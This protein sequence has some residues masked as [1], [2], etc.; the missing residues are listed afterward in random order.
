MGG[1]DVIDAGPG[2]DIVRADGLLLPGYL[3]SLPAADHGDDF[4]DAGPGDDLVIGGAASDILYGGP[5]QDRLVGDMDGPWDAPLFVPLDLH[6]ADWIDGEDGDDT[7]EGG[8]QGDQLWGGLGNDLLWGDL[9]AVHLAGLSVP[10]QALGDDTLDGGDGRDSLIGGGGDD[11]LAGGA[12][13]DALWGD[14]G[15]V[16]L[17]G[18]WHG[19]DLL[20]GGDGDDLLHGG[21]RNDTL[22][23]GAGRDILHGDDALAVL[24]GA[25]HGADLLDG[26]AQ[27]DQL[28]G[29]GGADTLFGGDGDD[30][31]VGDQAGADAA[32]TDFDGADQLH[33]DAG[34]DRLSGGGGA[35]SLWGGA[36]DDQLEGGRGADWMAGGDGHDVYRVDDPGDR[37][38]EA[39][40]GGID[41]VIST[42][43][44]VLPDHVEHLLLAG[45]VA[46]QGTG[47]A[48]DNQMTGT[49]QAD[50]LVGLAGADTLVGGRGADTLAGG[51]GDDVF[52]IDDSGDVVLELA[53]EGTD[54]LRTSVS[55]QLPE[56]VERGLAL[57]DAAIHLHGNGLDNALF[58]SAASNLLR[59]AGGNDLLQG[60]GGDDTYVF[61]PG[62]GQDSI[63][64]RDLLRDAARPDVPA[65]RDVL[66]LTGGIRAADVLPQRIGDD[67]LLQFRDSQDRVM[68]AGHFSPTETQGTQQFDRRID[69]VEFDQD[70]AWSAVDLDAL[71]ARAASNRAPQVLQ[72]LPLQ[73]ARVGEP[74]Q[75]TLPTGTLVDPDAWDSLRYSLEAPAGATLPAWIHFD[76]ARQKLSGTP[77]DG[78]TGDRTVVIRATDLYGLSVGL[79]VALRIT[80]PLIRGTAG[81]DTLTG[82]PMNDTLRGLAG[83]DLLTGGGGGD[84]F[85]GGSG[86]D[87]LQGSAWADTYLFGPGDGRDT[88]L[89]V[90]PSAGAADRLLLGPGI[91]PAELRVARQADDLVLSHVNGADQITVRG[92]FLLAGP[93]LAEV[94]FAD[95]TRWSSETLTARGLLQVGTEGNDLLVGT[96][97]DDSL[98]GQGG[99]DTLRGGSG[100]DLLDGG[101][102]H[103]VLDAGASDSR[104][105]GNRLLGGA[106]NDRLSASLSSRDNLLVGGP[107]DDALQGSGGADT[108][109]FDLG[110]GQD[111]ISETQSGAGGANDVL[112]FGS[113]IAPADIR[114]SRNLNDLILTHA[115]GT[116]AVT[117]GNWLARNATGS[118]T[119]TRI[120]TVQF[121]DGTVW[122]ST[123]LTAAALVTTGTA[124][125]DLLTGSDMDDQLFGLAGDDRLQGGQGRNLL[126]GGAGDDLLIADDGRFTVF[127]FP[128]SLVDYW[129]SNTLVGGAGNDT[130]WATTL[131]RDTVHEG[132]PGNDTLLG[133]AYNDTYRFA[134]GD[135]QDTI[136]EVAPAAG[137][138]DMLVWGAGITPAD[139]RPLRI[140]NDLVLSHALGQDQI[141]V[142]GWF[143]GTSQQIERL[144]FADGTLWDPAAVASRLATPVQG[145]AGPDSLSGGAGTDLLLGGDGADQLAGLGDADWLRGGAGNDTL[146]GGAGADVLLG[147]DPAAPQPVQAIGSLVVVA[148]GTVCEGLWPTME[149]WVGGSRLQTFQVSSSTW[150]PY[151]VTVPAGLQASAV[152]IVFTND[153][154]RPD[155]GQ[156]RNLTIDRIEID[157]RT[158][159]AGGAGAV[160]DFGTG[161]AAF[162]GFNTTLGAGTLATQGALRIGL[163]GGDQLDGGAGADTLAGGL[164]NDLYLVDD[165]ADKI[166]EQVG[167]GHDIV[168]SLASYVLPDGVEDLELLGSLPLQATGNAGMNTLRGNAA[169]NRLDGGPGSDMLVGGAG[170]DVYLVDVP[171]D[172]I[173]EVSGGGIDTVQSSTSYTLGNEIE[174]LQLVGTAPLQGTGNL[175]AN[176]LTGNGADNLLAGG[177]GNDTLAGE[178]GSDRL[179]GGDGQDLLRGD[180]DG[181]LAAD[182]AITRLVVHARG[183][184][185]ADV[186]P[187][188]EVRVGGVLL[189]TFTVA[190]SSLAAYTVAVPAG[191]QGRSVDILFTNDAARPDLGQDRNLFVDR[192]EI[193]GRTISAAGAG[194]VL[195]YGIGAAAL[196]GFNTT[197]GSGAITSWGALRIGLRSDDQLDGGAGADTLDGGPGQDLYLVDDPGDQIIELVAGGHDIVRTSVSFT[198][199]SNLEDLELIGTLPIDATGNDGPNTLRGNAA[200]NRLDGGAGA[201]MLVGGAGDDSYRVDHVGDAI[202]EVA[203]GGVDTVYSS[204]SQVLGN[205]LEH[206]VLTGAQPID[207]TGNALDNRIDGNAAANRLMGASGNDTLRG[208]A[209]QDSLAGGDGADLLWGDADGE[210]AS[211]MPITSLSVVARGSVCEGVWPTME[212]WLAGT[213]VQTV[214]VQS[215]IWT[216]YTITVPTGTAA[217]SVDLVFTNDAYRPDLGQDRNLYVDRI[218]VNGRAFSASGAGTVLDFGTGAGAVD[219]FN[220]TVGYG[221]LATQAGLRIGLQGGD[222][223][224][225]GAGADTLVGGIGNDVYLVDQIADQVLESPGN[226]HDIVRASISY[227]LPTGVEDLELAG[228]DP[229]AATGN[230]GANTLR[231]NAAANRLDGGAGN[232]LLV[233][234]LGGDRYVLSPGGGA[235]TIYEYDTTPASLDVAAFE[236]G[237]AFDQLWFRQLGNALE[238]RV[239]GTDDRFTVSGWYANTAQ[240]V[241]Q[242]QSSDG[243]VLLESQVQTLVQAMA[244]FAPPPMG[245][246][247]L[248]ANYASAL[249]PVL[250]A[251]WQ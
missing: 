103:D 9:P 233:G 230:A 92:W 27:D 23:G 164:G 229:I 178:G 74:F 109:R 141:T 215:S 219:G 128:A 8:G 234:G 15:S 177:A 89:E 130:L 226:G 38:V 62:D 184:V 82:G 69:R 120:E 24:A 66:R 26:G 243:R 96:A 207:G 29:G 238:V 129:A 76:A 64:N 35:D 162:D 242:F 56:H 150:A 33:G 104:S 212:V 123:V 10:A 200:A 213:R 187:Q 112:V 90:A 44:I 22:Q 91:L 151:A 138:Q 211:A 124:A 99:N 84:V 183:T 2:D 170:D 31:L 227:G 68:L 13:N 105:V 166:L 135:G 190:S 14:E 106:G 45:D 32:V 157:G 21:G 59:G 113:G 137:R 47:S 78:D 181:A 245:Q 133:S 101:A 210:V 205:A 5:G 52:D 51:L 49:A 95:G 142:T 222:Q 127:T 50:Q 75:W 3:N 122:T 86:D 249:A 20:D 111:R 25:F 36:G 220:T 41:T 218:E 107:G 71:A 132:G 196:D 85:D 186:W 206:L 182:E 149:V 192:I 117:V 246:M 79:P 139:I 73:Q 221:T 248:P 121:A 110:D 65:A 118:D 88:I 34:D 30:V 180:P 140:G 156:D 67:L 165:P 163:Q 199:A 143:I 102:G 48:R 244:A 198:L 146:D 228:A 171:S 241:E 39:R 217:H 42:V 12:G 114:V 108:Y 209:G 18:A 240:R 216:A 173:Y 43:D 225:G 175:L 224:D 4:V 160:L 191:T 155:L 83:Q 154:Y 193:D 145:T 148:R 195:D 223:L 250:A 232:D 158:V 72:T 189:Q 202:H 119:A 40:D 63:D 115:N 214:S 93:R 169:A 147:D 61:A 37:V 197:L 194:S 179:L 17:S 247:L 94:V 239:I 7:L 185:C 28:T 77:A 159:R 80:D 55:M 11:Q 203:G 176:R 168:R 144:Q 46:R 161:A 6:G 134:P 53:G 172:A 126:D 136:T 16:L 235:D 19:A 188:M 251:N 237:T 1:D 131:A 98:Q 201:D 125:R 70:A 153:A 97:L 174:H 231:G 208:G 236:G 204:V 57:G 167:G 81:N 54:T 87:T 152:D 60:G 100:S 116:D 58:G